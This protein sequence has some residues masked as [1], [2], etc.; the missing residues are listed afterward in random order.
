MAKSAAVTWKISLPCTR[1]EAEALAGDELQKFA[2]DNP[3]TI[4]TSEISPERT[5]EWRIDVYSQTAPDDEMLDAITKLALAT[6]EK[7]SVE[8]LDDE[9]WVTLSQQGLEPIRSG[10]FYIHTSD[11]SPLGDPAVRSLCI[12][13][14]QAFGTGHHETTLGCLQMLERLKQRGKHFNNVIDLGTGTGLLAFA[15]Q[16]LWPAASIIASDID[17][18]AVTVSCD[19]AAHNGFRKAGPRAIQFLVSNGLDHIT[20]RRKAPYNLIIANILAGPLVSLAPQIAA[21]AKGGTTLILAGLLTTQQDEVVQAYYR[22]GFRLNQCNVSHDWPCLLFV[23]AKSY[24]RPRRQRILRS[25]LAS[26]YFGE[27]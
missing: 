18:V 15:A 21:A 6:T 4:V 19:N 27:C 9:D 11:S 23:K 25:P 3:P 22:A 8:K 2:A 16:H 17:P 10:S 1:T 26:D 12:D 20:I 24:G 7:P 5:D 14:S 13:A